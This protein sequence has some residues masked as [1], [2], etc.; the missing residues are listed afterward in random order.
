MAGKRSQ[1]I[2]QS[3][4]NKDILCTNLEPISTSKE[5]YLQLVHE[6]VSRLDRIRREREVDEMV[7][8]F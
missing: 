4:Y 1:R 7:Q 6:L 8:D 2:Q 5:Q 3:S